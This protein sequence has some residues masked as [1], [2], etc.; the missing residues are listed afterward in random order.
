MFFGILWASC[1]LPWLTYWQIGRMYTFTNWQFFNSPLIINLSFMYTCCMLW[2]QWLLC[3]YIWLAVSCCLNQKVYLANIFSSSL[4]P[5]W[6]LNDTADDIWL[7]LFYNYINIWVCSTSHFLIWMLLKLLTS[8]EVVGL[9]PGKPQCSSSR[10]SWWKCEV[11]IREFEAKTG[12]NHKV[13][14]YT[15]QLKMR[16]M[17]CILYIQCC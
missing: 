9:S 6:G 5:H 11:L 1:R 12:A 15:S 10:Q 8:T 3:N 16:Q 14:C 13:F 2:V 7:W 4:M 17:L